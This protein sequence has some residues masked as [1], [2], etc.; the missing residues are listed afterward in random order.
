MRW[1]LCVLLTGGCA[2]DAA[3]SAGTSN[4]SVKIRFN[5]MT[6]LFQVE[7]GQDFEGDFEGEVHVHPQTGQMDLIARG[8]ASSKASP[9][10]LAEGERAKNMV[11]IAK[12]D[13]ESRIAQTQMYLNGLNNV[14]QMIPL[15]APMMHR[16]PAPPDPGGGI[17]PWMAPF[18]QQNQDKFDLLHRRLD[19][20]IGKAGT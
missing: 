9:V 13:A 14:M 4:P 8:K 15:L 12:I 6:K 2:F 19:D 11:E 20:L 18:I 5:P 17:P 1:I 16:P 7:T 3:K 10:V